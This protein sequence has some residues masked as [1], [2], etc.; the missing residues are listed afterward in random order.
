MIERN[1]IEQL[2]EEN[3][4]GKDLFLVDFKLSQTNH[5]EVFIDSEKSD[6]SI[7]D[8]VSL[9]R[10]IE[11][12][13]DREEEDFELNVSSAGLDIPLKDKRQFPKHIGGRLQLQMNDN[14]QIL[15]DLKEVSEEGIKGIPL[16]KNPNAKKGAK[17]QFFE[18]DE[19]T[20]SFDEIREA[21]IEVIF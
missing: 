18:M 12:N 17:K 2:I 10:H 21:K 9:S 19:I 7:S 5:I 3:L 20:L 13:L 4:Q 1:K 11:S 8:C 6:V 14:S 16:K 15:L